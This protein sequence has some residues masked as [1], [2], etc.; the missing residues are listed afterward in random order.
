MPC[1]KTYLRDSKRLRYRHKLLL[2]SSLSSLLFHSTMRTS[3]IERNTQ[4]TQIKLSLNL[5]GQGTPDIQTGIGFLDHML[6]LFAK[7]SLVDLEIKAQGDVHVDDHHTVEDVGIVLGQALKE[8]IGDKR[9]IQRYGFFLLP[10][11]E[12]LTTV[13]LDLSGRSSLQ[14]HVDFQ[15]EMVGDLS[16]ELVHDFFQS[17]TNEA[18][19]NLIIK[20]EFGRNT[21]HQIEGI[22]KATARALRMAVNPDQRLGNELPTTKGIL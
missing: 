16:T 18:K 21:H 8:A 22:F 19:C 10:M 6:T 15:R 7:H 1:V 14:L 9:G 11:D 3:S 2:N 17:L 5:D 12:C 13:A 20:S 4:E